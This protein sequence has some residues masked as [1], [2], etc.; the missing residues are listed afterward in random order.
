MEE[1]HKIETL[2]ERDNK[3]KKL[4]VGKFRNETFESLK[5]IE[6]EFTEKVDGTNIRIHWDG[7]E[8][9]IGGRTDKAQIP[10]NLLKRLTQLFLGEANAQ[11]FEQTFGENEVTLIGEGYGAG[12]Q[13]GGSYKDEQDFILFDV[14]VGSVFLKREDVEGIA[15]YFNVDA[16]PVALTGSIEQ[17]VEYVRSKPKSIIAKNGADMEGVVGRPKFELKDRLGRRIITKI[18]YCDF[19]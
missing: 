7:H 9:T 11:I 17:A 10:A 4:I 5:D 16:V 3:T 14:R 1:Y 6:W 8:V 13:T 18:K 19:E 2:F 15:R 12:I